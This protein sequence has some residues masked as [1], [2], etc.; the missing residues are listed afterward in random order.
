M[1]LRQFFLEQMEN[2]HLAGADFHYW[3]FV[4]GKIEFRMFDFTTLKILELLKTLLVRP[5]LSSSLS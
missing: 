5:G 3:Y 1:S 2:C 4:L